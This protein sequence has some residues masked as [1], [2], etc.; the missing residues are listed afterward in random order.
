MQALC[1]WFSWQWCR[2]KCC[3]SSLPRIFANGSTSYKTIPE[4]LANSHRSLGMRPQQDYLHR[5]M[6]NDCD[7][8]SAHWSPMCQCLALTL[9]RDSCLWAIKHSHESVR[10]QTPIGGFSSPV[11]R[12]LYF[13]FHTSAFSTCPCM[14]HIKASRVRLEQQEKLLPPQKST[15]KL[16]ISTCTASAYAHYIGLLVVQKDEQ[17]TIWGGLN[18]QQRLTTNS[19]SQ[20]APEPPRLTRNS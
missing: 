7:C 6:L 4:T 11:L 13:H 20:A 9:L 1:C 15:M 14:G 19:M 5:V 17:N 8:I 2:C 12:F 16:W 18:L 3:H 10:H